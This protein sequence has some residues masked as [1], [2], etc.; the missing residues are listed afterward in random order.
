MSL[1]LKPSLF[2]FIAVFATIL[3]VGLI[4]IPYGLD[5]A[6]SLYFKQ[7]ADFNAR[8]AALM[9]RFVEG[10]LADGQE[11]EAIIREFQQAIEGTDTDAGYVCLIDQGEVRYLSHPDLSIMGMAVKPMALFDPN[12]AGDAIN[13][14]QDHI[15]RGESNSGLLLLGEGMPSEIVHFISLPGVNW[16]VSSHENTA[17]VQEEVGELRKNVVVSIYPFGF[18]HCLACFYCCQEGQ[19]VFSG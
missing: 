8:M 18:G 17:R 12:F 15:R 2:T 10:R 14:W 19:Q 6:E 9:S 3:L 1:V 4:S 11:P 13:P 16:T 5:Y 7:Q